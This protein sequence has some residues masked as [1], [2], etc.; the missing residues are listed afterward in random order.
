M[1]RG[2]NL[3]QAEIDHRATCDSTPS[4]PQDR[5]SLGVADGRAVDTCP[6]DQPGIDD[7]AAVDEQARAGNDRNGLDGL[8]VDDRR[9]GDEHLGY[10]S[11]SACGVGG[12]DGA[13]IEDRS[14]RNERN[15]RIGVGI[16]GRPGRRRDDQAAIADVTGGADDGSRPRR[17]VRDCGGKVDDAIVLMVPVLA[18]SVPAL[19][20]AEIRAWPNCAPNG[21]FAVAITEIVPE[22]TKPRWHE[23]SA[24]QYRRLRRQ[25]SRR[26]RRSTRCF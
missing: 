2:R 6:L 7:G 1:R 26:W 9:A 19:M 8:G 10:R 21:R 4:T 15:R 22:L 13:G 3:D 16:A 14:A 17:C 5:A 18:K 20:L 11:R 12:G 23:D 24:Q 25:A